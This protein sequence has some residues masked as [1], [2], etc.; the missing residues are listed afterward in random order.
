MSLHRVRLHRATSRIAIDAA[1]ADEHLLGAALGNA[2]SWSRWRSVLRA[3]FALD[4]SDEDRK[5]FAEVA[6]NREPPTRRVDELWCVL[7]RRSGKTRT[8]AAI[9]VH[10]G[11]IEQHKLARG[12]VGYILLLAASR[13]QAAVAFSYVIGFLEASP[14]LRQQIENVT[15]HE[16]RLRGNIVIS[17]HASSY[18]TIRGRT[19]LAVIGDETSFWRDESSASPDVEIYRACVPALAATGGMWIGIST[20][21]RK[22]G[23]LYQK[24]RD[25]FG[26]AGNDVLVVQGATAQFN[27]SIDARVI[28][29]ASAADPEAADSEWNGGFR[30]DIAAFLDDETIDRAIDYSRPLE[31]PPRR[32]RS[33]SAF[34]DASG[35]RHD[36]FTLAIGSTSDDRFIC[37]VIRG[38][39]PPFDPQAVVAEYATLLKQYGVSTVVGDNYSAA[40]V[41]TAWADNDISYQRAELPKSGLYLESLPLFMRQ[42]VSIPEHQRLIR[43]MRLLERRT[44]RVGK[45]IVDHGRNGSDDF[46][47]ALAGLLHLLA[48]NDLSYDETLSWVGGTSS[49]RVRL[50]PW[51][52]VPGINARF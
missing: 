33:Y 2:A 49:T 47:N 6:G 22:V 11:A 27:P 35:G 10:I 32:G 21:Y 39:Q 29:K 20:G 37:D 17:V 23:L 51:L 50:N 19:L 5:A 46:V 25:H 3:A 41:E 40:W 30:N 12:E 45:D 18:R 4:M 34:S 43:E 26:V 1:L 38:R 8:A 44:S 42:A 52:S 13:S 36:A 16:V 14:V 15:A 24:W 7:G 48:G 31:L 28:A 9:A